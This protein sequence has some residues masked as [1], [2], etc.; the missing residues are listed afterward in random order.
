MVR[1]QA[2]TRGR[3]VLPAPD[4][5]E[6]LGRTL[7]GRNILLLLRRSKSA[8]L[9]GRPASP[10]M[11]KRSRLDVL[12]VERGLTATRSLAQACILAGRVYSGERRLDKPGDILPSD[13]PLSLREGPRYVSRGGD[14]LEGALKELGLLVEDKVCL[15]VGA[16]T[17]GFTDCL[18]QHGAKRVYAVDVGRGQLA[19]KLRRDARVISRES[20]NAR[21]L[22]AADFPEPIELVVV[23]ASFIGLGKLLPAIA[24]VLPS[25]GR[26]LA[27]VKP[28]FEAGRELARRHRGVI[29]DEATRRQI[30]E[31]VQEELRAHGFTVGAACDSSVPGP[32]GN[33]EHF[34]LSERAA[35]AGA[36]A[37]STSEGERAEG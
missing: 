37:S 3:L 8:T 35:A 21:H 29:K 33:V 22:R 20:T 36:F 25:G 7:L 1:A 26:L 18:L 19:D 5:A 4:G 9:A 23:D 10:L 28:Q 15:D 27:M 24:D 16:A 32:K 31:R 14:K 2:R 11:P 34:V 13:A 30:I 12:L 6:A 17:G